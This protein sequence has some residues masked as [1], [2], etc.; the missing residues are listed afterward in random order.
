MRLYLI[1]C[2]CL[3][4]SRFGVHETKEMPGGDSYPAVRNGSFLRSLPLI[5]HAEKQIEKEKDLFHTQTPCYLISRGN[6]AKQS[7]ELI[8]RGVI[9]R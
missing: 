5:R 1:L 8:L 2:V 9:Q 4:K 6:R 7:Y 3:R